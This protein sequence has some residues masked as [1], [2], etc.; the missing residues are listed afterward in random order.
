M[1][2]TQLFQ[3]EEPLINFLHSEIKRLVVTLCGQVFTPNFA[4]ETETFSPEMLNLAET[5]AEKPR[6]SENME[7]AFHEKATQK[8]KAI[9]YVNVRKHFVAGIRRILNK[10]PLTKDGFLEALRCL[11]PIN[12]KDSRSIAD[13]AVVAGEI[14][15]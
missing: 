13:I 7:R 2:F 6:V 3:K 5:F 10:C 15:N 4:T 1:S 8:Y 12:I 11:S 9:F 14:T